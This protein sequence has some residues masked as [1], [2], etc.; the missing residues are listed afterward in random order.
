[1]KKTFNQLTV[2]DFIY[3]VYMNDMSYKK[4]EINKVDSKLI[5]FDYSKHIPRH[6]GETQ[7]ATHSYKGSNY[8]YFT[9]E[10]DVIRFCKA[11]M[12]KNLFSKIDSAKNAIN[13][14]IKFR[15]ENHELLNHDWTDNEINKLELLINN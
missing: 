3:E 5:Y 12:M 10:P 6:V 1:M 11:R 8:F 4:M 9:H 14:V 7:E 13:H 15:E 2:G